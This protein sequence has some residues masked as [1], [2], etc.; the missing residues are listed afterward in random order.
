MES[1]TMVVVNRAREMVANL[2]FSRAAALARMLDPRRNIGTECGHPIVLQIQDYADMYERNDIASRIVSIYPDE[3]WQMDPDIFETDDTKDT[4]FET[5]WK[6]LA[7][8]L[9]IFTHLHHAD[10]ISGIGRLGVLILGFDDGGDLSKPLILLD[11]AGPDMPRKLLYVRALDEQMVKVRAINIDQTSARYGLPESYSCSF[12][13][14]VT[15]GT[16]ASL[17]VEPPK[18]LIEV[19]WTRLIH[20]ADNRINS[21]VYGVPRL[22]K[23]FNRVLDLQKIAGGSAEMFWKG[24][25]PGLSVET[26]PGPEPVDFDEE[27]TR[28]Q[29]VA[30]MNGLQ[31]YIATTGLTVKSLAV[32]IADPSHH[33]ET[34]IRLISIALSCP[35]RIFMG[36]EVGQLASE[37]DIRAWNSR[38]D[39]RRKRYLNPYVI[40]TLIERLQLA[41]VLPAFKAGT[42]S[43][44]IEWNDLN[45]PSN[46]DKATVAEKKTK[47]MLNY[48]QGGLDAAIPLREY[49]VNI[50]G[51]REQEADSIVAKAPMKSQFIKIQPPSNAVP[52]SGG[53]SQTSATRPAPG[54]S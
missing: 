12:E 9:S 23:V 42:E 30:Y 49:L 18:S 22:K 54:N 13:V 35:W 6:L 19:H 48:V 21:L 43:V 2:M 14:T 24:G 33:I 37:Q 25:F 3:S 52:G 28:E 5:A 7:E 39:R 50:M 10:V 16:T 15:G 1:K 17:D 8:R 40:N 53:R 36:A 4:A 51:M 11:K 29:M 47:A 34:Q 46:L 31:R 26:Q 41:G 27:T 44:T 38:I 45:T 32:Q 20:F